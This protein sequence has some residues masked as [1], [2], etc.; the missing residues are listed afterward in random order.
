M[1]ALLRFLVRHAMECPQPA[2][3]TLYLLWAAMAAAS[4]LGALAQE[5]LVHGVWVWKT[6]SVL[7]APGSADALRDFCRLQ[8]VNEVYLSFSPTKIDAAGESQIAALIASLHR[9]G[10]RVEALLSS[11]DAD[12]PGT[13]RDKLLDHVR[14]VLS[15]RSR[16]SPQW[17]R[18][19]PP[20]RRATTTAGEQGTRKSGVPPGSSGN[21]SSGARSGRA[22]P[23]LRQR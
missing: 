15:I 19:H 20:R 2:R 7:A 4:T 5:S 1:V 17:I 10:I 8:T 18:W 22:E 3:I 6:A 9:S 16:P 23:D 13:H 12:E 14:A 21:L 11:V